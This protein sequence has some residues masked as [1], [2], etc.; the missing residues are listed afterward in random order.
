MRKKSEFGF[1]GTERAKRYAEQRKIMFVKKGVAR[2]LLPLGKSL[3]YIDRLENSKIKDPTGAAGA[4]GVTRAT[5][6]IGS[7][8]QFQASE[9]TPNT[10]G[11]SAIPKRQLQLH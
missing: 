9:N 4:T 10:T 5:G 8:Q 6:A 11:S 1:K 2:S 3:R 7:F